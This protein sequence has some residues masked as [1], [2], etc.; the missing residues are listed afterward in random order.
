MVEALPLSNIARHLP[1]IQ[2][3]LILCYFMKILLL[4]LG[5]TC[6]ICILI[7]RMACIVWPARRKG[8]VAGDAEFEILGCGLTNN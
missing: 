5:T 3:K 7:R 2:T 8:R 4:F 1:G 6:L